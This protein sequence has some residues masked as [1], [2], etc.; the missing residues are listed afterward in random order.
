MIPYWR[1]RKKYKSQTIPVLVT[2]GVWTPK[3]VKVMCTSQDNCDTTMPQLVCYTLNE[4]GNYQERERERAESC[5][6]EI[7][8]I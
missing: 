3:K 1:K 7:T 8:S 5:N 6:I 4:S 2:W